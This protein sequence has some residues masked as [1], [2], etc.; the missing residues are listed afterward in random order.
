MHTQAPG[1]LS[2]SVQSRVPTHCAHAHAHMHAHMPTRECLSTG[3]FYIGWW[4]DCA[5]RCDKPALDVL[6]SVQVSVEATEV[7][8]SCWHIIASR[9]II[10]DF[11]PSLQLQDVRRPCSCLTFASP[12]NHSMIKHDDATPVSA[13]PVELKLGWHQADGSSVGYIFNTIDRVELA[14]DVQWNATDCPELGWGVEISRRESGKV[15]EHGSAPIQRGQ[16][17]VLAELDLTSAAFGKFSIH[18]SIFNEEVPCHSF[19]LLLFT[20]QARP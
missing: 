8:Q 5:C 4:Y 1:V 11:A 3:T 10:V 14:D 6:L 9:T 7:C 2:N 19:L 20:P 15:Y 16:P 18:F 12:A 17:E 13:V